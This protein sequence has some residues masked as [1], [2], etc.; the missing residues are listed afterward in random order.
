MSGQTENT[1]HTWANDTRPRPPRLPNIPAP[2]CVCCRPPLLHPLAPQPTSSSL[3]PSPPP[4]P[5]SLPP[6]PAPLL[7][8]RM[9]R[10]R[11]SACSD[12]LLTF[13]IASGGRLAMA[14]WESHAPPPLGRRLDAHRALRSRSAQGGQVELAHRWHRGPRLVPQPPSTVVN[15]PPRQGE[16]LTEID[17]EKVSQTAA[18]VHSQPGIPASPDAV[19]YSLGVSYRLLPILRD[20]ILIAGTS[21]IAATRRR[22]EPDERR[23]TM[24]SGPAPLRP[25]VSRPARARASPSV[26]RVCPRCRCSV[27]DPPIPGLC[28][29]RVHGR[30]GPWPRRSL[31]GKALV[32]N[33]ARGEN[34][35]EPRHARTAQVNVRRFRQARGAGCRLDVSGHNAGRQPD[36]LHSVFDALFRKLCFSQKEKEMPWIP[37]IHIEPDDTSKEDVKQLYERTRHSVTGKISDLTRLTSSTPEV[38]T[39]LD[40]LC[41]AVYRTAVG[42][43]VREKE[44][45]ALVTSAFIGCV[46]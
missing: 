21:S 27:R 24:W 34:V 46:H 5:A 36:S 32:V 4:H 44:I 30:Y 18:A 28:R 45:V 2:D 16:R 17:H 25:S 38:S 3:L 37:W 6:F 8:C 20:V 39:C 13:T 26:P 11:M 31:A 43:T 29:R 23:M 40:S 19:A 14:G 42:L 10:L 35:G 15:A 22:A 7:P 12:T 9:S 1:K 33:V 41:S